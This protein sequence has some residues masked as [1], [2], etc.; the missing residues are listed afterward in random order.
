LRLK[1]GDRIFRRDAY[2]NRA[3]WFGAN[4][5]LRCYVYA[6]VKGRRAIFAA[7]ELT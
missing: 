5:R 2:Q 3:W 7:G 4:A 1:G 6:L